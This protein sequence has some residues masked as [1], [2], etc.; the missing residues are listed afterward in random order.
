[1]YL[2]L[3]PRETSTLLRPELVDYPWHILPISAYLDIFAEEAWYDIYSPAVHSTTPSSLTTSSDFCNVYTSNGRK[4]PVF[5]VTDIDNSTRML[6]MYSPA[7]NVDPDWYIR[8][9]NH[10]LGPVA[11]HPLMRRGVRKSVFCWNKRWL[12]WE[13]LI[14]EDGRLARLLLAE[15]PDDMQTADRESSLR[16]ASVSPFLSVVGDMPE[17]VADAQSVTSADLYNEAM[18]Q[19]HAEPLNGD[20]SYITTNMDA[21][22]TMDMGDNLLADLQSISSMDLDAETYKCLGRESQLW[23]LNTRDLSDADYGQLS[24]PIPLFR[25]LTSYI[26]LVSIVHRICLN[27]SLI[28]TRS[29]LTN[30]NKIQPCLIEPHTNRR[31]YQ[32]LLPSLQAARVQDM[33]KFR[34]CHAILT[35]CVSKQAAIHFL[36]TPSPLIERPDQRYQ[37]SKAS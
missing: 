18:V 20:E 15:E 25:V 13:P 26:H 28:L 23:N 10:L 9:H 12:F 6:D 22:L 16:Y 17:L 31:R 11:Y 30:S 14:D 8:P 36:T 27:S 1:M 24:H 33:S 4:L 3:P 21:K 29:S 7:F 32:T 37:A 2:R 5:T 35:E 19:G 34:N